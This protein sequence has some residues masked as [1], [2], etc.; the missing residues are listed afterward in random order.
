MTDQSPFGERLRRLRLDRGLSQGEL[1]K[2]LGHPQSKIS[3]AERGTTPGV[4]LA[5]ALC[6][7]YS[8]LN[9]R[10]LLT[11]EGEMWDG[12]A[13]AP[14]RAAEVADDLA[15][16]QMADLGSRGSLNSA[17]ATAAGL[18]AAY[19][20]FA[21]LG[22]LAELA[23]VE[24]GT[25]EEGL[26]ILRRRQLL[27]EERQGGEAAWRLSDGS[28]L[29]RSADPA[30]INQHGLEALRLLIQEIVPATEQGRGL[31]YGAVLH[32]PGGARQLGRAMLEALRSQ[33]ADHKGETGPEG[34]SVLFG[35]AVS[36][37]RK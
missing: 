30:N 23:E 17:W 14:A 28:V 33:V 1:G 37:E 2:L 34:L 8:N 31:L 18:T 6:A 16:D 7:Q 25:I 13:P 10:W 11:G 35:V 26:Q 3:K 27:Q 4:D 29:L 19:P 20:E 22:R 32:L 5:E 15:L 9:A 21:T 12:D 24:P 36:G